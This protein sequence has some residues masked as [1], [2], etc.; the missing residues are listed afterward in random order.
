MAVAGRSEGRSIEAS[1]QAD[2]KAY[3]LD[4]G[5][6]RHRSRVRGD[7]WR[8]RGLRAGVC[9]LGCVA[10]TN[11]LQRRTA[12][13]ASA[14]ALLLEALARA[15]ATEP[16]C[17]CRPASAPS[18]EELHAVAGWTTSARADGVADGTP[19]AGAKRRRSIDSVV[20]RAKAR[21][22]PAGTGPLDASNTGRRTGRVERTRGSHGRPRPAEGSFRHGMPCPADSRAGGGLLHSGRPAA[23]RS[24]CLQA[25]C[26]LFETAVTSDDSDDDR[27]SA[28]TAPVGVSARRRSAVAASAGH[29]P[30]R[31]SAE[32][33]PCRRPSAAPRGDGACA[34][35]AR[36]ASRRWCCA[37]SS[38]ARRRPLRR[39]GRR[40]RRRPAPQRAPTSCSCRFVCLFVCLFACAARFVVLPSA[41]PSPPPGSPRPLK[42]IVSTAS[43]RRADHSTAPRSESPLELARM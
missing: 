36:S 29:A 28:S 33:P 37:P 17:A 7:R 6:A 5:R 16:R 40:R 23:P 21:L 12:R 27:Q 32:R 3:A 14:P 22:A 43:S 9:V 35:S 8:E 18:R 19:V 39:R 10:A 31:P 11:G 24:R 25:S 38:P 13:S 41:L 34:E 2:F 1:A 42:G 26:A 4:A 30:P 15:C 20:V